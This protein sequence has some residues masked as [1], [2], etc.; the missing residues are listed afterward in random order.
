MFIDFKDLAG[1]GIMGT[2]IIAFLVIFGAFAWPVLLGWVFLTW[3]AIK[4]CK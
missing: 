3:L 2:F 4:F 1:M